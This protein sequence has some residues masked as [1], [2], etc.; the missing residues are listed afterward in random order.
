MTTT[1]AEARTAPL[2]IQDWAERHRVL[3]SGNGNGVRQG[4]LFN[5]D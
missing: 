4:A 3:K 1:V 5:D 2:S